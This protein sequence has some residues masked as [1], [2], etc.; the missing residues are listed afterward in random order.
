M[1]RC[2]WAG[3]SPSLGCSCGSLHYTGSLPA[4]PLSMQSAAGPVKPSPLLAS[5]VCVCL[6]QLMGVFMEGMGVTGEER[7]VMYVCE[8]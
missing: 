8:C 3:C 5:G 2:L 4:K 1:K 6:L 7:D